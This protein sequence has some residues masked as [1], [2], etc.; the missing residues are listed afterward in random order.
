MD[1]LFTA[2]HA[3]TAAGAGFD[4]MGL[5]PLVL[6]FVVMYFLLIR[7]QQKKGQETRRM[8]QNLQKGDHILTNGGIFGQVA[9]VISPEQVSLEIADGVKVRVA[10]S[11]IGSVVPASAAAG[12]ST[13]TATKPALTAVSNTTKSPAKKPAAK[14]TATAAKKTTAKKTSTAKKTA[15]KTTKTKSRAASR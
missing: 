9:K 6:V 14:K 7:P 3:D 12:T 5:L 10:T 4:F 1:L 8:Q 15:S 13:T 11:M 2:A